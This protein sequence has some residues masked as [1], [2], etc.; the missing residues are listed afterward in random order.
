MIEEILKE[1]TSADHL[2]YV[3]MKYTK[4]CDVIL[5][6][7]SRWKS[8]IE[9]SFDAILEKAYEDKIIKKMPNSHKERVDRKS[10]V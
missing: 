10:V 7:I 3:S 1:K 9:T 2:F 8:M 5:N 4:T 6:L